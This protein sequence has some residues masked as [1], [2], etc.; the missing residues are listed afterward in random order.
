MP[1]ALRE[2]LSEDGQYSEIEREVIRT[3][4]RIGHFRFG[5]R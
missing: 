3:M 5:G 1:E 2:A 4:S